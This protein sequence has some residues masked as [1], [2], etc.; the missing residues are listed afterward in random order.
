AN[1]NV[2]SLAA[3]AA[4]DGTVNDTVSAY[5]L[6][7][8]SLV[9]QRAISQNFQSYYPN[10]FATL[11][12]DQSHVYAGSSDHGVHCFDAHSG[13][14]V[15]QYPASGEV[16]AVAV[17][18]D[19]AYAACEDGTLYALDTRKGAPRW[20]YATGDAGFPAPPVLSDGVVYVGSRSG[21]L[22]A[23]DAQTGVLYWRAFAGDNEQTQLDHTIL[24][25]PVLA[26]GVVFA[27]SATNLYAF[28]V[29][30]GKPRWSFTPPESDNILLPFSGYPQPY[31]V[32]GLVLLPDV[33]KKVYA[34]NP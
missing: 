7:D 26:R 17:S 9:W 32:G 14:P 27:A 1:G 20:R 4:T 25:Q 28:N 22:Y 10:G 6:R 23:L 30:N 31:V 19:L 21:H 11:A 8:G 2:Y 33:G 34:L 18:G 16:H 13:A 3:Y 15:W 24:A 5:R 12:V 29:S